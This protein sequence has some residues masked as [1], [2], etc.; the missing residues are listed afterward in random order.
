MKINKPVSPEPDQSA[1][2]TIA[3]WSRLLAVLITI[4][5][6]L[7]AVASVA[8]LWYRFFWVPVILGG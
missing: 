4:I 2:M 7:L 8:G 3:D 6:I 5:L 1:G